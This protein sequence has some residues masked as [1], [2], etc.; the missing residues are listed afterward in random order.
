[1]GLL[2]PIPFTLGQRWGN[3]LDRSPVNC[4]AKTK[5]QLVLL[6][7]STLSFT[8]HHLHTLC[9]HFERGHQGH[10]RP[11]SLSQG[12]GLVVSELHCRSSHYLFSIKHRFW[13][14]GGGKAHTCTKRTYK[15]KYR[16]GITT[17]WSSP[18]S[19]IWPN[20]LKDYIKFQGY[21]IGEPVKRLDTPKWAF[22]WLKLK[23]NCFF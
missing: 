11:S 18:L 5:I 7:T 8:T 15:R 4:S 12:K 14:T 6:P 23:L 13:T 20:I 21:I 19:C 9:C 17:S 2:G 16:P 10:W 22:G 3:T 1:M